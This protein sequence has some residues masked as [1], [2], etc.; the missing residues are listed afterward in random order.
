MKT[1]SPHAN[2]LVRLIERGDFISIKH[3]LLT[4]EAVSCK[5]IPQNWLTKYGAALTTQILELT[6]ISGYQYQSYSTGLYSV[7]RNKLSGGITLIFKNVISQDESYLIFNADLHRQRSTAHGKKGDP[8]PKGHFRIS[9][10]SGFYHFW[11]GT[12]L[13]IPKR[14][15]AIHGYMGN[16]SALIFAGEAVLDHKNKSRFAN[17]KDIVP[18]NITHEMI[19]EKLAYHGQV[20]DKPCTVDGQLMHN[21]WTSPMDKETSPAQVRR[22]LQPVSSTCADK[23]DNKVKGNTITRCTD[24]IEN[25]VL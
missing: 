11:L 21:S 1:I 2:L 15:S 22:G 4:I 24:S 7:I 6:A 23:Y 14:V 19:I 10:R 12:G 5:A 18:L 8:L 13:D 9:K 16:L 25:L 20:M 3:G 17:K